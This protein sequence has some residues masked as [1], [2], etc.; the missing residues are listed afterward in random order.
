MSLYE[1]V[2]KLSTTLQSPARLCQTLLKANRLTEWSKNTAELRDLITSFNCLKNNIYTEGFHREFIRQQLIHSDHHHL[3]NTLCTRN[4][5]ITISNT[6]RPPKNNSL[7]R[8]M[9][10]RNQNSSTKFTNSNSVQN[11]QPFIIN[12]SALVS[13]PSQ[14]NSNNFRQNSAITKDNQ[15]LHRFKS[16][17]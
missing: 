14:K 13:S 17:S 10:H 9:H 3:F 8:Q 2:V 7:Q 15:Q 1:Q 11:I 12:P 16:K 6:Y 5:C 4:Y